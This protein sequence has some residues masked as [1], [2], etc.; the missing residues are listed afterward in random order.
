MITVHYGDYPNRHYSKEIE[1]ADTDIGN[2]AD[3]V[4]V[5]TSSA[6]YLKRLFQA[7]KGGQLRTDE[8]TVYCFDKVIHID[9]EGCPIEPWGDNLFE[10]EFNLT[11]S[12]YPYS[13][14]HY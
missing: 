4:I 13:L 3:E 2:K 12:P 6:V 14:G 1:Q 10:V 5:Y 8:V 11:F 9:I 7:I